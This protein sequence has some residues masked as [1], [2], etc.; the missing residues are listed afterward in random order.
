MPRLS[1]ASSSCCNVAAASAQ[2]RALVL[3]VATRRARSADSLGS[4]ASRG[5][6][7]EA[8]AAVVAAV[9]AAALAVAVLGLTAFCVTVRTKRRIRRWASSRSRCPAR[10]AATARPWIIFSVVRV[11]GL[12]RS[13]LSSS[14]SA[15]PTGEEEE[16]GDDALSARVA[17]A[18]CN[19]P[20]SSMFLSTSLSAPRAPIKCRIR[21]LH[22]LRVRDALAMAAVVP[23]KSCPLDQDLWRTPLALREEGG[24]R[25]LRPS[26]R[27]PARCATRCVISDAASDCSRK[28]RICSC[29]STS[30]A[31]V[32]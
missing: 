24:D 31:A 10:I 5:E 8:V 25:E 23:A 7:G 12:L 27:R 21:S 20:Q 13:S 16:L 19:T 32:R 28:R 17:G 15:L 30:S 1:S 2:V 11:A 6:G 4:R 22:R 26:P 9:V 29:S 18:V 3:R 14:S